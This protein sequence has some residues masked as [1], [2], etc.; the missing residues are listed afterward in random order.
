MQSNGARGAPTLQTGCKPCATDPTIAPERLHLSLA[1]FSRVSFPLFSLVR[2][3]PSRSDTLRSAKKRNYARRSQRI[4]RDKARRSIA[5]PPS[6]SLS[7]PE[8]DNTVRALDSILLIPFER[9]VADY[10][11]LIDT[12]AAGNFLTMTQRI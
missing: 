5:N 6:L 11:P 9:S 7:R 4:P 12:F 8:S 2:R 3:R 10:A 1:V